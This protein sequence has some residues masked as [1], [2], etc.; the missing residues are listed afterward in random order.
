MGP[1]ILITLAA[2]AAYAVSLW[3]WP[4]RPC[5]KCNGTGRNSGSSRRRFGQ[6]TRCR[7]SGRRRRLGAKTVHRGIANLTKKDKKDLSQ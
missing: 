6:C 5:S 2:A 7:G 3:L 4:F 1:V